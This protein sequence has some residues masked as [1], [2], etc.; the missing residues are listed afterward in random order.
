[1][2]IFYCLLYYILSFISFNYNTYNS[3]QSAIDLVFFFLISVSIKLEWL[4]SWER[5][6]HFSSSISL[7]LTHS[8]IHTL[9]LSLSFGEEAKLRCGK[10]SSI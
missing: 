5:S 9:S 2:I 6:F 10:V 4:V 1:M 7:S 3:F 8:H